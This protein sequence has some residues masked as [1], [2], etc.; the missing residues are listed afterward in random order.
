MA[1]A[2]ND[3]SFIGTIGNITAYR[4]KGSDKIFL[5]TK[6]G[7][8][9]KK[10]KQSPSFDI[11]R[12]NNSEFGGR[13]TAT[14]WIGNLLWPLRPMADY[15]IYG[16]LNKLIKPIQALD[17]ESEFGKRHLL[18]SR[19]PRLLEG[20]NVNNKTSFDSIIRNPVYSSF[21][22]TDHSATLNIPAL[23]PG[24]NFFVPGKYPLFNIVACFSIL[25]DL[26]YTAHGYEPVE[27][28]SLNDMRCVTAESG[29]HSCAAGLPA[30]TL[31]MTQK[32]PLPV[33]GGC[34]LVVATGIRFGN[35]VGDNNVQQIKYVGAGK[36]LATG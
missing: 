16:A 23:Q 27:G 4:R 29:W 3:F 8:S 22:H 24:I 15:N 11:T 13:A 20:F 33:S 34:S 2:T 17:T 7:P 1:Q 36:I 10:I 12:R 26:H 31:E 14:K 21:S 25:P 19:N 30:I 32:L 28:F 9:K 6:G 5:R 18:F 35:P